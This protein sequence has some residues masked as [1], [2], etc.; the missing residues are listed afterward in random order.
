MKITLEDLKSVP[1]VALHKF[2]SLNIKKFSGISTD[3]R[4]V[5]PGELFF[6][7]RGEKFN[8][9]EFVSRAFSKG[10]SCAV[11]EETAGRQSWSD[12]P[13]FIVENSVRTLGELA[14]VHRQKFEIP[15]IAVAGSNGKTTTKE[16]IAAVLSTQYSVLSTAGNLNNNI[17]VPQT[18]FG[19]TKRHQIAVI[20]IGTNHFGELKYLCEILNPTHG[21]ITNIGH[22]HLEYF[23]NIEG[24]S[25]GE[26]E[27]YQ[28]ISKKGQGFVNTDDEY[29]V[30]MAK[31]L[32]NKITYGFS[33]KR[34]RT[35][36]RLTNI[37]NKGCP[38]FSVK[39]RSKKE[40]TIKLNT[41]GTHAMLNGL[42]AA[43]V[44]IKFGIKADNI[45][46]SLR[47]FAGIGKR[48]E[49]I[50]IG[51]ATI[52]NDT[53]NANTDSVRSALETLQLMN[54]KGNKIVILAD[55]LE[56]GDAAMEEH[57]AIGNFIGEMGFE[58]LLTYGETAKYI[59]DSADVKMKIHYDQKNIL[60]E[61]AAELVSD[62]DIVLVKGSRGMKME[63]V[64]TFLTERLG[65]RK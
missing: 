36:G 64:V 56:L 43:A 25:K 58:Y 7:I 26:G 12:F 24:V 11:V 1:H 9:H 44:G 39:T 42:A 20:E 3:S 10:A 29:V 31:V 5:K 38:E 45:S 53:Y 15:I 17:G 54:C 63:D 46:R 52:I 34:N 32:K 4:S 47:K 35:Q 14:N 48:M 23:K 8:G 16:M 49:I 13:L 22:E 61:Y 19:L 28:A 51:S 37:D 60:S 18:L 6:A 65:K 62:G 21:L 59:Y 57:S 55:M 30:G 27:L 33:K 50:K 41:P 2:E 40:F